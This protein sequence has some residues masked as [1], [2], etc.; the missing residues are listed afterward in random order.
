M[1]TQQTRRELL[2]GSLALA[3]LSVFGIPEWA[4]PALAQGETLVPF[5]DFPE[6]FNAN[7]AP[8][9]R[10]LDT[11]TIDGP[12]TPSDQ[13]FTTQHYGHPEV[14]PATYRLKVS[15]LVNKPLSLSIEDLRKMKSAE[16]VAGFECSGNRRPT[17]GLC[18]NGRWT[19]VPLQAVLDQAGVKPDAREFVFFGADRGKEV[20]EFRTSKYEVEQQYGRSL[21]RDR[22]LVTRAVPRLRAQWRAAEQTPGIPAA[23][24]QPGLVRRAQRQVAGRDPR[25]GRSVS[26]QVPGALVSHAQGR[27]DQRRDEVDGDRDHA[28]AAQVVHRAGRRPTARATPSPAIILTTVRPSNRSKSRSTTARGSRRR[29]TPTTNAK[30]GWKLFNYVWNGAAKGEHTL[31]SRVIDATGQVQP[32]AEELERRRRSSRTTRSTRGL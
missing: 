20:V 13:F 25:A 1:A 30:Y 5:T 32:T 24:D 26:R 7:P 28:H 3:G 2:K 9:R 21:P 31:V 14:D 22:A 8:D 23:T 15:G 10:L 12:F 16:L 6:N 27:D 4:L 29:S 18:S 11:R 19:G 17:Q